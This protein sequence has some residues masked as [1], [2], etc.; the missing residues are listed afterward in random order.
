MRFAVLF[1]VAVLASACGPE[2]PPTDH[3]LPD[4]AKAASYLMDVYG[5]GFTAPTVYG[6]PS[7][8]TIPAEKGGPGP[9]FMNDGRCLGG[10][11]IAGIG[12]WIVTSPDVAWYTYGAVLAH[13]MRHVWLSVATGD[14]DEHHHDPSFGEGG[15][16]LAA[17]LGLYMNPELDRIVR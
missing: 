14:G 11:H 12:V 8:C 13:E 17:N 3:P 9:G 15:A 10:A 4:A 7:N 16:V 1:V 5:G 2:I 6:V